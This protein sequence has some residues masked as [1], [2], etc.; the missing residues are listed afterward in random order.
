MLTGHKI[1]STLL[2]DRL[3]QVQKEILQHIYS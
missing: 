2:N 3:V 1:I